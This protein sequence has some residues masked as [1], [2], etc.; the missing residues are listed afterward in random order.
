M[1]YPKPT[2][3]QIQKTILDYLKIN[4]LVAW[5]KRNNAGKVVIGE[6]NKKRYMNVGKQGEAD[7][8]G[9]LKGGRFFA[10]E[11]KRSGKYAKPSQEEWLNNIRKYGGIGI[12]ANSLENVEQMLVE[13]N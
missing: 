8:I 6:G 5:V 10:I 13:I 7:V 11:I 12:V 4:P 2:E 9:M 1:R 3:Q